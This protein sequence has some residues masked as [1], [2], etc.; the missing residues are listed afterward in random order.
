MG[1]LS[2]N[3]FQSTIV[4]VTICLVTLYARTEV[5]YPFKV[6]NNIFIM[7]FILSTIYIFRTASSRSYSV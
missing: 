4:F 1:A 2:A 3:M 5:G 6:L 7:Q